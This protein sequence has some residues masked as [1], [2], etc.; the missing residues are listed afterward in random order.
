[1]TGHQLE[2]LN[3][4]VFDEAFRLGD[5]DVRVSATTGIAVFP[6]D[7][8]LPEALLGNAEVALRNARLRNVRFLLYSK[9]MN[10]RV[11]ESLRLENRVRTALE[12]HEFS[13]WYQPK[14][15][16]HT[17]ELRGL[18]AL[19]RWTDSETG[20]MV[21]PDVFIPVMEHTGL[22]LQ[23]GS[24]ALRQVASDCLRWQ[25]QGVCAPRV[26][27]NVSPIQLNQPDLVGTLIEAQVVA[28][29]AGSA[30]DVEITESVIM[31]DVDSI[32]PKLR[33]FHSV[34]TKIYVDDF[35]TGYSSLSYIAKLP[36]DALKIDRSFVS[37]L[38]P[39]SE[40]LAIVKSIIS[41]AKAMKLQVIAEGVETEEQVTLLRDLGCDELQGYHLGRPLPPDETFEVIRTLGSG[42][43]EDA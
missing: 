42:K 1:D 13:M 2:E 5:D 4:A 17:G 29:E 26:A 11:A 33:T 21:P 43:A 37:D 20:K 30:I 8:S 36:I 6:E 41:L 28:K 24:W 3:H 12:G 38:R 16:A 40:G 7:G 34:G 27:V 9:D 22:I 10:E 15:C 39:D 32:I 31:D 18:E 14:V 23:A 25:E 19:M 35:G